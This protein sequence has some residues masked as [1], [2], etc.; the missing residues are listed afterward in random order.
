MLYEI[1]QAA[2]ELPLLADIRQFFGES[3]LHTVADVPRI[4]WVPTEDSYEGPVVGDWLVP[5]T[6]AAPVSLLGAAGAVNGTVNY[7]LR[8]SAPAS[9]A[10]ANLGPS[11]PLQVVQEQEY[12]LVQLATDA[13]AAV[14]ST[15]AEVAAQVAAHPQAGALLS[16]IPGGT[17][18]GLAG[19]SPRAKI[20]AIRTRWAGCELQLLARDWLP[21]ELLVNRVHL[22]LQLLAMG[23]LRRGT[24]EWAAR[25]NLTANCGYVQK[26]SF[27]VPIFDRLPAG[28]F[29]TVS[30]ATPAS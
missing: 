21:L 28:T 4:H 19:T 9:I 25:E 3:S 7:S 16:G 6:A 26:V 12:F 18:Q 30:V 20:R 11:K 27:A 13:H 17:G 10:H 15:A 14:T 29:Q 23:S 24:G 5:R 2:R 1:F 8:T 22:A